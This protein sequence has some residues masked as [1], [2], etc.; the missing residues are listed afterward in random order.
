ML[1]ADYHIHDIEIRYLEHNVLQRYFFKIQ[2]LLSF[3]QSI[4]SFLH[5]SFHV[6][7]PYLTNLED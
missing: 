1:K 3:K 5:P 2:S 4:P 6:E 7:V